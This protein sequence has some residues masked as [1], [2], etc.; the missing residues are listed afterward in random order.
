MVADILSQPGSLKVVDLQFLPAICKILGAHRCGVRSSRLPIGSFFMLVLLLAP[1]PLLFLDD[2]PHFL[3]C[4]VC[5]APHPL[6][7]SHLRRPLTHKRAS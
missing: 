2:W 7:T 4:G 3:A 6:S 1:R 5:T